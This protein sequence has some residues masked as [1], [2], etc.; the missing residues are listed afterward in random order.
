[1]ALTQLVPIHVQNIEYWSNLFDKFRT[2]VTLRLICELLS[3]L[4]FRKHHH[5]TFLFFTTYPASPRSRTECDAD[6]TL[7]R[8]RTHISPKA[9]IGAQNQNTSLILTEG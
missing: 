7:L 9:S 5:N 8:A 1:M 2:A 6:P 3:Q 4:R